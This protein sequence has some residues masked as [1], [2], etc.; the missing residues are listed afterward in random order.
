MAGLTFD[1]LDE[2]ERRTGGD[3]YPPPHKHRWHCAHCGR[4]VRQSTVTTYMY[5]PHYEYD[6]RGECGQCG[7]VEV[8]WG[9]L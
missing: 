2:S 4:F 8:F 1:L 3:W 6:P 5:P 9:S 7:Q